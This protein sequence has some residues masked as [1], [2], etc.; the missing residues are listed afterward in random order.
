LLLRG[1]NARVERL[2]RELDRPEVLGE[3]LFVEAASRSPPEHRREFEHTVLGPQRHQANQAS[4]VVLGIE[5][6]QARGSDERI[7]GGGA[8]GVVVA[9]AE[10]PCFSAERD[11]LDGAL[12]AVVGRPSS[13][14]R[15]SASR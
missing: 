13:K 10:Q 14:K 3:E 15:R 11:G 1:R 8:L 7:E 2:E 5:A 9:A 4:Q 6:V 12:G